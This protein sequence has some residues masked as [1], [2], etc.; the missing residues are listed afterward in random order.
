MTDKNDP[1]LVDL[2][3]AMMEVSPQTE[4]ETR[5]PK[6]AIDVKAAIMDS[7][8]KKVLLV[9]ALSL[10]DVNGS[11]FLVCVPSFIPG[12]ASRI[13][14]SK[15]RDLFRD[16]RDWIQVT[17]QLVNV[18]KDTDDEIRSIRETVAGNIGKTESAN[19]TGELP[20]V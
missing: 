7:V 12:P 6:E 11:A 19:D 18:L 14:S 2:L 9:D 15:L 3:K 10:R 16:L 13:I 8:K 20:A 17:E 1:S 5:D 4:R